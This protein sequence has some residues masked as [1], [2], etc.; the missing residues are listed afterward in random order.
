[1]I[2]TPSTATPAFRFGEK[3]DPLAMY[4]QDVFTVPANLTGNPGI[5]VPMGE[6]DRDGVRLPVG[7]QFVAP[8]FGEERLFTIGSAVTGEEYTK[9]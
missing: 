2:A 8:H 7:I 4:A 5:S 9:K 3:S 6:V 1:V